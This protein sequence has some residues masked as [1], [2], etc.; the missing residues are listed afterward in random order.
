[1]TFYLFNVNT[2]LDPKDQLNLLTQASQLI[3]KLSDK[4]N[5]NEC[6]IKLINDLFGHN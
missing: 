4:N 6:N 3:K 5:V 1:M 2:L